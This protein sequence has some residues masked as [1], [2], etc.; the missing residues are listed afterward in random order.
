[1]INQTTFGMMPDGTQ[2]T[3][4]CLT[5]QQGVSVDILSLGGIIRRWLIPNKTNGHTDIVLGYDTVADYL[6]DDSYLGALV[7]RYAN[8]IDQ[9]KFDLAGKSYQTDV[10]QG[11]NCLHGGSQG[12]N[13]KIWKCTLLSS[14]QDPSLMLELFSGDGDQGFPADIKVKVIYTLTEQNRLKIEYFANSTQASLFNPTNHSYF[15]LGGHNGSSVEEHQLQI[16]ASFYTPT[17]Q[18]AIPTGEIKN[19]ENTPFDFKTLTE[20]KSSLTSNHQQIKYGNGLDH[21]LCLDN[22]LKGAKV[23]SYAGQAKTPTSEISLKVYTTMPGLQLFTANHFADKL[24]KDGELYQAHQ[25]ICFETQFYP[26][27]PN[28]QHFPSAILEAKEE[29][30]SVTEYEAL[31]E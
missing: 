10:N 21:N 12:F 2:V 4:Y 15:N 8:R 29:F 17:D 18:R 24:G 23:T 1:V 30:Y 26:D 3:Q 28:H 20:I 27:S 25:G 9:G 5:N 22:Y 14:E 19:V 7:G 31:F 16:A 13:T 11:G 6:A